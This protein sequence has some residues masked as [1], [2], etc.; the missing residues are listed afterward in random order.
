MFN[1]MTIKLINKCEINV[2]IV[3][4]FLFYLSFGLLLLVEQGSGDF[5]SSKLS[6]IRVEIKKW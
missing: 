1:N 5:D 3:F 6:P 4:Y 2:I